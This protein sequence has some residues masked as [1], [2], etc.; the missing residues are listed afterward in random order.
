MKVL[1][2]RTGKVYNVYIPAK[3]VA[4]VASVEKLI[5]EDDK[6]LAG[7]RNDIEGIPSTNMML[8]CAK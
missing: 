4:G 5:P 1:D 2:F 6:A 8:F 3:S 7:K